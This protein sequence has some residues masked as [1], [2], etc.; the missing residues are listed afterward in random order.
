MLFKAFSTSSGM[1]PKAISSRR[2]RSTAASLA[3]LS[4]AQLVPPVRAQSMASFR[5]GKACKSGG[6]KVRGG[7]ESRSSAG[8]AEAARRG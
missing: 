8:S 5:Q 2:K 3:P 7:Q 6:A 4:T 1:R